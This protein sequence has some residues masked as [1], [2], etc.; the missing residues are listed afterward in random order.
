[1]ALAES[2]ENTGKINALAMERTS[3]IGNIDQPR[4]QQQQFKGPR[5]ITFDGDQTLYSDGANF[6]SNRRLAHYLYLLLKHGVTVAVVTAAGYEYNVDKYEYRL[7][8]LLRYFKSK[9]LTQAECDSFYLFGGECNYLLRL[10]ADYRLHAVKEHGPGGWFTATRFLKDSPANW[11]EEQISKLLDIAQR[12]VDATTEELK[13][14]ARVIRKRRS[15]GL[16]PLPGEIV[17]RESLDET[18]LRVHERLQRMNDGQGATLPYCAFN[19]GSDAWVDVGNKRVGVQVLQTY[20]GI[21]PTE[22]LHIGDQF[23]NT[24]NDFAARAAS[25][26]CWIISPD[27]TT[28]IIK[29]ILRQAGESYALD[30]GNGDDAEAKEETIPFNGRRPSALDFE[31]FE[32]RAECAKKMD[33]YTGEIIP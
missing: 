27:E 11:D 4:I 9:G 29:L 13:L 21:A 15:V 17:P 6:E 20:V 8:G 10:G 26:C 32:R 5:L 24:G 22:T 14:R 25:P 33:I 3:S 19:G 1:M 23:L 18:V 12:T 28:H 7:S 31:E 16:A 30:E 2:A